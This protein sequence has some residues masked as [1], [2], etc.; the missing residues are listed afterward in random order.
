MADVDG[1]GEMGSLGR[2]PCLLQLLLGSSWPFVID[3]GLTRALAVW[4]RY[5]YL[6][7]DFLASDSMLKCE[8]VADSKI[9][10]CS[11]SHDQFKAMLRFGHSLLNFSNHGHLATNEC[12]S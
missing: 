9:Q 8:A 1:A 2:H 6:I 5:P 11:G 4:C 7:T 3:C 12:P 10:L